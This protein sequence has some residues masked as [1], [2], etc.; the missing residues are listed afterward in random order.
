L[1]TGCIDGIEITVCSSASSFFQV[2]NSARNCAS[3]ASAES[4]PAAPS[5]SFSSIGS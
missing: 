2:R 3:A 5:L 1:S 4:D